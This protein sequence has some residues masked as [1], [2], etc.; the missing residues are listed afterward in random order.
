MESNFGG[1]FIAN[2][3]IP[4]NI[5][6][7]A[8]MKIKE[9]KQDPLIAS[10]DYNQTKQI[11]RNSTPKRSEDFAYDGDGDDYENDE[12]DYDDE[13][14]ELNTSYNSS[15]KKSDD[16][17]KHINKKIKSNKNNDSMTR[18]KE[19]A[20]LVCVVCSSPANGYNFD[21]VTCESCKAFFRRNAFRSIHLFRCSNNEA[22]MINFE[23][24]KKCKKCR[25][26]KCFNSGMRRDWIM[27][28]VEREEKRKKIEENR[29]RKLNYNENDSIG[30]S[31][32]YMLNQLP[33]LDKDNDFNYVNELNES[34]QSKLPIRRRRRRR[35]NSSF[36][37]RPNTI[38]E[39]PSSIKSPVKNSSMLDLNYSLTP[40]ISSSS[41]SNMNAKYDSMSTHSNFY[42]PRDRKS[43][44]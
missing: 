8:N 33:G 22:C 20:D 2:F 5:S 24:R 19:T 3:Q 18:P 11:D 40:I 9:E 39:I 29:R 35:R 13:Y 31:S 10:I 17:S 30:E 16:N 37:K 32:N 1:K 14:N 44:V 26:M 12:D 27:T 25:I 36:D 7:M 28:D 41:S 43:V 42:K 21:A 15:Y 4:S 34:Y 6:N 23:T 38:R